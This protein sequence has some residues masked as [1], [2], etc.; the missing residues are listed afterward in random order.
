MKAKPDFAPGY[1]AVANSPFGVIA[2][3]GE[4]ATGHKEIPAIAPDDAAIPRRR[5]IGLGVDR[6]QCQVACQAE[7]PL[8]RRREAMARLQAH[9]AGNALDP[10]P[11]LARDHG[12]EFDAFVPGELE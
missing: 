5:K 4:E 10:E 2:G 12:L 11:A 3:Q 7:W 6:R 9:R 8:P 1:I